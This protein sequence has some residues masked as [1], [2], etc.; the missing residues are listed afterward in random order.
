MSKTIDIG[1][2]Y[3]QKIEESHKKENSKKINVDRLM[4]TVGV[5]S[6]QDGRSD[7]LLGGWW[8]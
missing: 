1:Y 6:M 5:R 2:V 4:S 8:L 7:C 3:L